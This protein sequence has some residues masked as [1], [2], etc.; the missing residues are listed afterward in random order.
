MIRGNNLKNSA[1]VHKALVKEVELDLDCACETF[2]E[3][4]KKFVEA[5]SSGS[6]DKPD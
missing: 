5:S 1:W 4:Q 3:A 6:K 2:M